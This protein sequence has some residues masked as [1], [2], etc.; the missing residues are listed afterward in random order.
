MQVMSA[1]VFANTSNLAAS[2]SASYAGSHYPN[3]IPP[4]LPAFPFS[5]CRPPSLALLDATDS[6][7]P[8]PIASCNPTEASSHPLYHSI[9]AFFRE[10][11]SPPHMEM[12]STAPSDN[13]QPSHL[14][15]R[16]TYSVAEHLGTQ[17]PEQG[18]H[19]QT[20]TP[21]EN[22]D[23]TPAQLAQPSKDSHATHPHLEKALH[24]MA[25]QMMKP[26]QH[27]QNA[28]LLDEFAAEELRTLSALL[29]AN[30][31]PAKAAERTAEHTVSSPGDPVTAMPVSSFPDR[32]AAS[33]PV[34]EP[35][36]GMQT[37]PAWH[38]QQALSLVNAEELPQDTD[39]SPEQASKSKF[40]QLIAF[41]DPFLFSSNSVNCVFVL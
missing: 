14:Q 24:S 27:P 2:H 7:R 39:T 6:Y 32:T 20:C 17:L 40:C 35:Q 31:V 38:D 10:H 22:G 23:E 19:Q 21:V 9:P 36:T 15:D 29:P 4:S 18:H 37:D 8:Q 30:R 13:I 1:S 33:P 12:A 3:I 11:I 25:A 26:R 5:I 41:S 28:E 16:T 34:P